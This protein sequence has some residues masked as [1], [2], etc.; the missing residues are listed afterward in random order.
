MMLRFNRLA[1]LVAVGLACATPS[2]HAGTRLCEAGPPIVEGQP[3]P[4]WEGD[5]DGDGKPDRLWVRPPGTPLGFVEMAA[6]PWTGFRRRYNIREA[7][8]I[9]AHGHRCSVIQHPRFFSTPIWDAADK[10]I[11][12]L[13]RSDPAIR[14]WPRLSR[15]WRG[16]GVLLGTEAGIDELLLWDGRR[17]R[18]ARSA[19]TP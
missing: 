4:V 17:W 16:D 13:H 15:R 2:T 12:V 8:L 9:V 1:A 18:I 5:F 14:D 10:P 7:A 6:D 19:D 3:T 11:K